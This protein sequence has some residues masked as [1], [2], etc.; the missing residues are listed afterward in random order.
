MENEWGKDRVFVDAGLVTLRSYHTTLSLKVSWFQRKISYFDRL[1]R[2]NVQSL[3]GKV[4]SSTL[5]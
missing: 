4:I 3:N 2:V 1:I 5:P